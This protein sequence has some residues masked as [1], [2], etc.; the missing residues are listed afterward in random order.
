MP[1]DNVTP[2]RPRRPAPKPPR[3]PNRGGGP[4]LQ[5]QRGR[6]ILAQLLTLACFALTFLL[7][8]PPA[9]YIGLAFGVAALA[10]A[11]S[12]RL[13][14]MPWARTHHE[15]ALR[16]II[17]GAVAW[18]LLSLLLFLQMAALAPI[19]FWGRVAIVAWAGLRAII[20]LGLAIFRRAIPNPR[21]PLI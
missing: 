3:G 13:D 4:N 19:V 15:H 14:G 11:S 5:S 8:T 12:N 1:A 18:T 6:A 10:I 7:V 21:G 2:F 9:S 20:G 17:I 16:T